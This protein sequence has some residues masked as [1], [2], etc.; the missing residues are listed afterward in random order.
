MDALLFFKNILPL[1][2]T[3]FLS[4][5]APHSISAKIETL[6]NLYA[7]TALLQIFDLYFDCGK[8]LDIFKMFNMIHIAI[9]MD[10][11]IS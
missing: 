5:T 9:I 1:Y 10:D 2:I 11:E 4:Q 6:H 3:V 8:Y 7:Q